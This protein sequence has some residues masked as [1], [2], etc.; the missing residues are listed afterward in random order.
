[1]EN[2]TITQPEANSI[3]L[4]REDFDEITG[5]G[6]PSAGRVYNVLVSDVDAVYSATSVSGDNLSA[7]TRTANSIRLGRFTEVNVTSGVVLAYYGES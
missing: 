2:K 5:V 3:M 4:G 7:R 6:T 1:M